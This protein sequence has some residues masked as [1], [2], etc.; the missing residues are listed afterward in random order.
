MA[1]ITPYKD[2][3]FR[4]FWRDELGKSHNKY[5]PKKEAQKLYDQLC[6]KRLLESSGLT[7]VLGIKA[8]HMQNPDLTFGELAAKYRDDYLVPLTRATSNA[9]YVDILIRRWGHYRCDQ[10]DKTDFKKWLLAAIRTP[11]ETP[12][13]GAWKHT[14]LG[15]KSVKKIMRYGVRI[16]NWGIDEGFVSFNP[17]T[18]CCGKTDQ[19]A[20]E[21]RRFDDYEAVSLT[22]EEFLPMVATFPKHL[23]C[24]AMMCFYS[25]LRPGE[26]KGVRWSRINRKERK[27]TFQANDL[28]E[29]RAKVVFYDPEMEPV[30]EELWIEYFTS[31]KNDDI[32]FRGKYGGVVTK[33]SFSHSIRIW[34]DKYA[35]KTGNKKYCR[36]KAHNHRH[37][38]RTRKSVEG[39]DFAATMRNMGHSSSAVSA[40]YDVIDE[41][42]QRSVAGTTQAIPEGMEE[43]VQGLLAM[44]QEKGMALSD[45]QFVIRQAYKSRLSEVSGAE[46]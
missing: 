45:V 5:L 21:L 33:N 43:L 3:I 38:Y 22:T 27:I 4:V 46:T 29:N 10:F 12:K 25:G 30:L 9:Y 16:F 35:I 1:S 36:F 42:R 23:Y 44:A 41:A 13:R 8:K 39:A 6:A 19:L 17:L 18:R 11:I 15:A 7:N 2:G 40:A 37:S 31:G 34:A 24:P 32:V 28:K 20:K 14:Q 26:L